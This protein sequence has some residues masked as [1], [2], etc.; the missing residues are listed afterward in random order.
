V[1]DPS[2]AGFCRDV[3]KVGNEILFL[4][5]DRREFSLRKAVT[6]LATD[7]L[8]ELLTLCGRVRITFAEAGR[9]RMFLS[10]FVAFFFR[11]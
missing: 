7:R 6:A 4:A 5:D 8:D 9:E 3:F 1:I 10:P 2:R 11:L